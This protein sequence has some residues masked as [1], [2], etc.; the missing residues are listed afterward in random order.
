MDPNFDSEE[1]PFCLG[2][3]F[4]FASFK[5]DKNHEIGQK[6]KLNRQKYQ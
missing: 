1:A 5:I 2:I 4:V 6:R 3:V